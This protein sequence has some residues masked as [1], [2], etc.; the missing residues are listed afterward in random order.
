[1]DILGNLVDTLQGGGGRG[2]QLQRAEAYLASGR[3]PLYLV[4]QYLALRN[5]D[6]DESNQVIVEKLIH[7]SYPR[8]GLRD[9]QDATDEDILK[10]HQ[11]RSVAFNTRVQLLRGELDS[12]Q[13]MLELELFDIKQNAF[14]DCMKKINEKK[15]AAFATRLQYFVRNKINRLK[16]DDPLKPRLLILWSYMMAILGPVMKLFTTKRAHRAIYELAVQGTTCQAFCLP[17][18]P[19]AVQMHTWITL[20]FNAASAGTDHPRTMMEL[21]SAFGP[22]ENGNKDSQFTDG[23]A[24]IDLDN[25]KGKPDDILS[26]QLS[27]MNETHDPLSAGITTVIDNMNHHKINKDVDVMDIPTTNL[28]MDVDVMDIPTNIETDVNVAELQNHSN[29]ETNIIDL[30]QSQPDSQTDSQPDSQP[31]RNVTKRR[32]H[33]R[34]MPKYFIDLQHIASWDQLLNIIEY[35]H[36]IGSFNARTYSPPQLVSM[37]LLYGYEYQIM[38]DRPSLSD[39]LAFVKTVVDNQ[40]LLTQDQNCPTQIP[41]PPSKHQRLNNDINIHSSRQHHGVG[42]QVIDTLAKDLTGSSHG[43]SGSQVDDTMGEDNNVPPRR[44]SKNDAGNLLIQT[45]LGVGEYNDTHIIRSTV[46]VLR[47]PAAILFWAKS[48]LKNGDIIKMQH[49]AE[50]YDIPSE[51]LMDWIHVLNGDET[52]EEKQ[53]HKIPDP[54]IPPRRALPNHVIPP[55][56][57]TH[58]L[59][60]AP[61]TLPTRASFQDLNTQTSAAEKY[62]IDELLKKATANKQAHHGKVGVTLDDANIIVIQEILKKAKKKGIAGKQLTN[63]LN[64]TNVKRSVIHSLLAGLCLYVHS[65]LFFFCCRHVYMLEIIYLCL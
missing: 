29:V 42:S 60:S 58:L 4:P 50:T 63:I 36:V 14:D 34:R 15:K 53:E 39:S 48:L 3:G 43:G 35:A 64:Q 9:F 62:H 1:M 47:S 25:R 18:G 45:N 5:A 12:V 24:D 6:Q 41:V 33:K 59:S 27:T 61:L 56:P 32:G 31:L 28:G 21:I 30:S 57:P 54:F 49:F 37:A 40:S 17:Q 20:H 2:T 46:P 51:L 38:T 11:P 7:R 55:V 8:D 44:V 65:F 26:A 19:L 10:K 23:D 16:A 52:G 13:R 22:S